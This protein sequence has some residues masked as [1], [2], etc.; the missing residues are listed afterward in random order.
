MEVVGKEFLREHFTGNL[1]QTLGTLP[2]VHSMD[3]GSGFSKPM[4]RGMGFNRISVV[5]NGIKQEGQQWGADHGLELDAFNAGQVSI[6][7]GPASLLYGSDAMGG[8][9]ELVP[10]PLPA[11]NRL[12]GEASL[13]GKSVNGT[14]GGSLML[15]VKKECLVYLGKVFGTTLWGLSYSDG[16]YCLPHPTYACLSPKA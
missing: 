4:I 1:I 5:E 7:K 6:R 11:G 13:L 12:F 3:I 16:Y 8:A 15:G 14:L 2:G 9:I 10:L